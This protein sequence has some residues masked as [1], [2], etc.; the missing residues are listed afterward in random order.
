MTNDVFQWILYSFEDIALLAR[1]TA[2]TA[3][4]LP[5]SLFEV[6][7]S[8]FVLSVLFTVVF[9]S[10][11]VSGGESENLAESEFSSSVSSN[12][13]GGGRS[14]RI[15]HTKSFGASSSSSH[16]KSKRSGW[17]INFRL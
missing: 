6:W 2:F 10:R 14:E 3:F 1:R 11:S 9:V 15:K 4:G 17:S 16:S 13:W 7:A 12:S 8:L 5:V